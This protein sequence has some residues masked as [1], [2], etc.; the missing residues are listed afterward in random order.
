[1]CWEEAEN[2]QELELLFSPSLRILSIFIVWISVRIIVGTVTFRFS[3]AG[4]FTFTLAFFAFRS[5]AFCRAYRLSGTIC[6]IIE[7]GLGAFFF[8]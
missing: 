8:G 2:T 7:L 5:R 4:S 6:A 1:M 3:F